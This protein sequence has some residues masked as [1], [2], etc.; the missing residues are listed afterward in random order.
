[1]QHQVAL[2]VFG[3]LFAFFVGACSSAP[4][5]PS[6][7][8]APAA[9]QPVPAQDTS[10]ET[11]PH[12]GMMRYPAISATQI[13]FVYGEDLWV[14]PREGGLASPLASPVGG[15]RMPRFSPD[16]KTLSFVA[17][18]DGN[19][20]IYTLPVDGGVPFRVTHHPSFEA[21][22]TWTPD[23]RILFFTSGR[24]GLDRQTKLY[25][26]APTGG[27]P[28]AL[29]VP[30]GA[31]GAI[32]G[33]GQW[34]AYTPHTRDNRTWKRYRG[35]MATDIWLVN[36]ADGSSR[37]ITDWEGTDTQ[38]MWHQG[39]IYYLSD[40]GEDH[41][42][43]L[44][45]FD[46]QSGDRTQLTS[47][48]ENDVKWPSNG[49]GANGEG[50]I[51]FQL[52]AELQVMELVNNTVRTVDVRVPGARPDLRPKAVDAAE[53]ITDYSTAPEGKRIAVCAR[54]DIWSV[55]AEHGTPRNLTRT[56]GAFERDPAWSPDG[57]WIAYF[58]DATGEFELYVTQ[59]DGKGETKQL[60]TDGAPY[61]YGLK[62][63]PDS[64][65][66]V[67]SD[68]AGHFFLHD[69]ES[70]GTK[71]VDTDPLA[72]FG[73]D[74]GASW[75]HD[76]S[77]V[78]YHRSSE[79]SPNRA[80]ML[81][82]VEAGTT[83]QVTSSMFSDSEPTFD[84]EGEYLYY[85]SNRV[86]AP[87]Y[88]DLDTSFIYAN[89]QTLLVVPLRADVASPF[90]PKVDE[91]TWESDDD[92]AEGD[93]AEE[94]ED[95]AESAGDADEAEDADDTSE[96]AEEESEEEERLSI[97]L[98]GFERRA[99][100]LPVKPGVFR[101]LAVADSGSL[102]YH[103]VTARGFDGERVLQM[104]DVSADEP[105]EETI[106]E[107]L[108]GFELSPDGGKLLIVQSGGRASLAPVSAGAKLESVSTDGMR[109]M[110]DPRAEWRQILRDAWRIHRDFFYVENM[111]GVDWPGIYDHYAAMLDD[112]VT[113]EDVS[114]LIR[115]MI[116]ELNVGH[117]Y[118]F[119]GDTESAD[120]VD[121]GM[122][123]VDFALD[124]GAY[125]IARIVEGAAWDSDARG[126][127]S[128][129]GVDVVE[130]DYLLAVDG[131]ALDT[132][133][134]PWAAFQGLAGETVTLTVSAEPTDGEASRDVVVKLLRGE[135]DLR[136]RHWVESRR[137]MADELSG[138]KVGYIYVPDTGVDGQNELVRQFFGQLGKQ[139]LLIDDRWNGGGQIPTRFIEMLNR[140]I[141]NYWARRDG[142]DWPWPP[143]A[144]QGPKAML[145]NGLAGSGGDAFP[146]YFKQAG[147]GK[148]VGMRT[149]GGLV[150]I[151]GNPGLIDGGYTAVPT[152]G[153]YDKDGTWGIEGHGVDPDIE[154]IDDPAKMR[155]GGDPQ[156]E[157][158]VAQLLEE[159]KTNAYAPPQRPA[160]PDR[161]GMGV[162]ESDK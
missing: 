142:T 47:F 25:T 7:P 127:L 68:K 81:Y 116:S 70:G 91:V 3:P 29:P 46:P 32:S 148:L 16:G 126:P 90:A 27:L 99:V 156:L 77:W 108:A 58:S 97:D 101:N 94:H 86:F 160:A 147:L 121:V 92:K 60:T 153:Y 6:A 73:D 23:G 134:D 107:G 114:Y 26:V 9:T 71:L 123:G 63:A 151:S 95:A 48:T 74:M 158:A 152:F 162:L 51:V 20:E 39:R 11:R 140:P 113:R 141:T 67:F 154:V 72:N 35:G 136:Y 38:P 100:P 43:N 78:A 137:R 115:E 14:V 118:Y 21:P 49:P 40:A 13:A 135:G 34:L 109:A 10:E 88:G 69:V 144:H 145:I 41:R 119:G 2:R 155:D 45:R 76:S 98:E 125:R 110:I 30:Y 133:K 161:S 66:L 146:A 61:R 33:D 87:A 56:S 124:N 106:V 93:E 15:E 18:Y 82:D 103:R 130:G 104:M 80:I 42:L 102:V 84:R 132:S 53:F 75:S 37:R 89:T 150:G 105:K 57:R 149:W 122:L 117:A 157:A 19:S 131:V 24:E 129:P 55:A 44:W 128:Q 143:D 138:G 1:M 52:G 22:N 5:G 83:H 50:E 139:A 64:K 85:I 8:A 79:R 112:C 65:K 36:L 120:R 17:N 111:H 54:G 96:E 4:A 28:E 31:V 159:L 12:G 62:W 59:S